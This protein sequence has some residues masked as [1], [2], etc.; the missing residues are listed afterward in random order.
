MSETE[1]GTLSEV[2][3]A[4]LRTVDVGLLSEDLFVELARLTV[5]STVEVVCL[6]RG[7][8][9]IEVLLTQRVE[10]DP[11]WAG[12]WHSPGSVIR[13]L[14]SLGS[15]V[16]AFKRVL[17]G[18][19]GLKE[20]AE[21]FFVGPCFWSG[22]RGAVVSQVH[23]LDVTNVPVPIGTF[24]PVAALPENTIVDMDKVIVMAAEHF[25]QNT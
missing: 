3:L 1:R 10:T 16:G 24:F 6:R 21:P 25:T 20:W 19:L 23:W 15:F 2:A 17:C 13:P 8:A 4:E 11:F 5:L 22:N 14:D 12:Q 9:G 7:A 18:E